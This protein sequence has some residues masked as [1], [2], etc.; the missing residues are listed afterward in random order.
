MLGCVSVRV[1][2]WRALLLG[3]REV[4]VS[5]GC[6]SVCLHVS[7]VVCTSNWRGAAVSG[8]S[9]NARNQG[10]W[11]P[12]TGQTVLSPPAG[13]CVVWMLNMCMYRFLLANFHPAQLETG[14]G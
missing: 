13:G 7:E 4:P 2:A 10:D 1:R 5:F 14:A 8:I 9:S 3:T 12:A 6:V 11:D